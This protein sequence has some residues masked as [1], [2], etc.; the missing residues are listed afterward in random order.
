MPKMAILGGFRQIT[1]KLS[2]NFFSF[3]ARIKHISVSKTPAS[4]NWLESF[5]QILR[6]F[7]IFHIME[8]YGRK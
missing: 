4:L 8:P 3:F 7:E 5:V 6:H 1:K 2:D